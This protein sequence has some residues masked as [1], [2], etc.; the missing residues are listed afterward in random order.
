MHRKFAEALLLKR[1]IILSILLTEATPKVFD[2]PLT[3]E[4][5]L[6]TFGSPDYTV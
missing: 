6:K 1:P 3:E 5:R 2:A 4:T